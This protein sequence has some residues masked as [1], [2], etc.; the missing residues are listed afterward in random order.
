MGLSASSIELSN[1]LKEHVMRM[2]NRLSILELK[3]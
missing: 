2:E 1:E 3:N